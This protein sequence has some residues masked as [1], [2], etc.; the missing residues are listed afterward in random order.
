M[1][2]LLTCIFGESDSDIESSSKTKIIAEF[3]KAKTAQVYE[4]DVTQFFDSSI[5]EYRIARFTFFHLLRKYT[6]ISHQLIGKYYQQYGINKR[7]ALYACA[8]CDK[9]LAPSSFVSPQDK[10]FRSHY[11]KIEQDLIQFLT[12][13][14]PSHAK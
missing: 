13:I 9:R 8:E 2:H 12:Q 1:T 4:L 5:L 10:L 11:Y 14:N 7:K 3:L 6:L